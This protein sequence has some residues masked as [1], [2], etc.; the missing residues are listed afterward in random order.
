MK[1]K[2]TKKKPTTKK[3][4]GGR[5]HKPLKER[6]KERTIDFD[7]VTRMA[8]E[9]LTDTQIGDIIGVSE[10]S[11]N[12]WKKEEP[13]FALALK[14]GK[15]VADGKVVKSLYKRTQGYEY[16][17]VTTEVS[18]VLGADGRST[19]LRNRSVKRVKKQLAPDTTACIFWLKNRRSDEWRDRQEH[20][21][22]GGEPITFRVVYESERTN[23]KK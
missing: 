1:K 9:G 14:K 20:T 5:P 8:E 10:M 21:G 17:E 15:A 18:D 22:E 3:N 16:E 6:L 11:V 13:K 19:G 23:P 2:K 4:K 7:M 12:T